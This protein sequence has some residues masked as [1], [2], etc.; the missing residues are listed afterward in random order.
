MF[1]NLLL[2][3]LHSRGPN[4]RGQQL[5][6]GLGD[7]RV[8]VADLCLILL[9]LSHSR[10]KLRALVLCHFLQLPDLLQQAVTLGG[11]GLP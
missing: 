11:S 9:L 3:G 4:R 6:L 5:L 8:E 10:S 2:Q 7:S 1:S